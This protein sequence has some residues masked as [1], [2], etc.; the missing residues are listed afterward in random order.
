MCYNE[1]ETLRSLVERTVNALRP[2]KQSFEIL[3]VDDGSTDGSEQIAD[4]L[5]SEYA[6]VRVF[7]HARNLGIGQGLVDSYSQTRGEI[8][9]IIP[10]DAQFAPED[11]PEALA[12]LDGADVVNVSREKRNDPPFR[13]FIS[14]F[15]RCLALVLFGLWVG[16]LHWVKVCRR[17]VLDAIKIASRTPL[18][19]IELLAKARK[20]GFTIKP[21]TLPHH[22]RT[23]G[24]STGAKLSLLV[25]TFFEMFRLRYRMTF[26]NPEAGR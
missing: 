3:I 23:A 21:V 16:D 24:V 5:G 20:L 12:A 10:G 15:D 14:T 25:K 18:V 2:L 9:V 8:A 11:L 7:H 6:E 26:P 4:Q 1:A 13:T 22:P 17:S 19:D